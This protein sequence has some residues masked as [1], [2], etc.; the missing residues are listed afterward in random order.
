MKFVEHKYVSKVL[1]ALETLLNMILQL[2]S[3]NSIG[4]VSKRPTLKQNISRYQLDCY[5]IVEIEIAVLFQS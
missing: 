5:Y 4:Q 1:G 2:D 3:W